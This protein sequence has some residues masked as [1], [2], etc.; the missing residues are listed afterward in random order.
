MEN[1]EKWKEVPGFGGHYEASSHGRI[2]SKDR[3]VIKRHRDGEM[4]RQFYPSAILNP[5]VGDKVG[6]LKVHLG[7]DGKRIGIAVHRLVLLAFIGPCPPGME[8]CHNNGIADD[9]R[10]SNLRWDT[11]YNNNQDRKTHGTYTRGEAHP[12]A[13]LTKEQVLGIRD[14]TISK[15]EALGNLGISNSQH[16]R[17]KT[18]QAWSHL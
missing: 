12:M 4:M 15:A 8:A 1:Q 7:V 13:K 3:I 18:K 2:R 14:G 10:P 16:H 6:H 5:N 11:H 17:I 9:N